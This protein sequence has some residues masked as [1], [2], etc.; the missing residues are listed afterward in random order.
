MSDI[1]IARK[2]RNWSQEELSHRA[3]VSQSVISI[4]ERGLEGVTV[5]LENIV[6]LTLGL[7]MRPED[8]RPKRKAA[9]EPKGKHRRGFASMG[10]E[11]RKR[12]AS[13]GG[14]AAHEQGVA[15]EWTSEETRQFGLRNGCKDPERMR[16]LGRMGGRP[17]KRTVK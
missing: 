13:M 1:A 15:H 2:E 5:Y 4:L 11:E 10:Q 3:G 16:E 8:E 6:R 7:S 17:A 9:P 14:K 12:I